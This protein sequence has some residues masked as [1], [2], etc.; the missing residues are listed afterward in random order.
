[1][2]KRPLILVTN[3]DSINAKGI[4]IL[5]E[6]AKKL[7]D[8]LVVAPQHVQSG[9]SSA[10]TSSEPLYLKK[11][12]SE[13]GLDIYVCS[14]TPVDCIKMAY[15]SILKDRKP[16]L[17]LSGVNHGTNSSVCVIYSGTMG[18]ALEGCLHDTPSIGFSLTDFSAEADF[19]KAEKYIYDI[20]K[21]VLENGLP[22]DT[23]LNVNFPKSNGSDYNGAIVC[24]QSRGKWVEEFDKKINPFK[25]E[26]YWLTG[27]FLNKEPN[28]TDTDEWALENYFVSVVPIIVDMT[29]HKTI[30][31]LSERLNQK[32]TVKQN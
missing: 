3:D 29:A 32:A 25:K 8:V 20:S 22:E 21:D 19:S 24:R 12:H 15:N 31:S 30:N 7:G 1:M 17:V 11:K 16:D 28:A 26:Y 6:Q 10:I 27:S 14:G 5:I 23:C 18:A 9:Q 4:E 13:E 2:N